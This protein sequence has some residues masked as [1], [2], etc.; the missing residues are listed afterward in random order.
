M[1]LP[2]VDGFKYV[3]L[4][5]DY[6]SKWSEA[7]PLRDKS[8]V[9]VARFLYDEV[10]CRHGCPKIQIS[11][12]GREFVNKLNDELSLLTG[13]TQRVTSAYHPQANGL[14]E[15]QNRT[16]KNCL[17]KVLQNEVLKWPSILQGVLFAHRTAQHSSTG[18]SPFKLLYQREVTLPIDIHFNEE[19]SIEY[20]NKEKTD[21]DDDNGSDVFDQISFNK[22]LN[23]MF[24]MRNVMENNAIKNIKEA[25]KRQR[26]SYD[27]KHNTGCHFKEGD[28]VLARNLIRDDRKG[29]WR[30]L[31][32][33]GPYEIVTIHSGNTCILKTEFNILKKK[34]H[35]KNLKKYNEY[36]AIEISKNDKFKFENILNTKDDNII[37]VQQS[38][39]IIDTRVFNP[40]TKP[41][42]LKQSK[43]LK[44]NIQKF[45]DYKYKGKTLGEPTTTKQIG[46]DG[47][48]LFRALSYWITGSEED[49]KEIRNRIT[50]VIYYIISIISLFQL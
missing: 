50:Q 18:Y 45:F 44:L 12:Q 31:P 46:G 23:Q 2:E 1:T 29:G 19:L 26:Y 9:S 38:R 42:Q 47:N 24:E 35:L 16:I 17:L 34:F 33:K 7:R 30:E 32:W 41:W 6:F 21:N 11:D 22:T 27:K 49:H 8:A 37:M 25:Q 5:I 36:P 43:L 4:A 3:V 15:R 28:K 39:N 40:V 14:V 20:V 10:V 13:T 48:C